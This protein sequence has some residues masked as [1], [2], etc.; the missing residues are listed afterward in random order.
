MSQWFANP[1]GLWLG[2]LVGPLLLLY[3]LRHK[4]VR[5]RVPSLLLWTGVAQAQIATS[6]FQRLKKSL[7][8]LLML[9]SLVALVLALSGL[10]IPGGEA[11]GVPVTIVIDTTASM[12]AFEPGGSRI[13]VARERA[14]EVI[15]AAGNSSITLLAWDGNLH[16]LVPADSEPAVA[17]AALD[18]LAPVQYGATDTALVR[19]L[20]HLERAGERRVVLISDHSPGELSRA[21]FVPCGVP[22]LNA[23]FVSAGLSEPRPGQTDLFFAVDLHGAEKPMRVPLTLERIGTASAE[24]VDARDIT[25]EPDARNPVTFANMRPGLYRATL[26]LDDGLMLDNTAFLRLSALPVQDVVITGE[27]PEPLARALAAIEETMGI[28][29]RVSH[30]NE[31]PLTTSYVFND[32]ASAG[33]EPRLPSAYLAPHAPPPGITFGSLEDVPDGATRPVPSFLWRGA[34]APDVRIPRL[35]RVEGARHLRP[36]LEAGPGAAIATAARDNGL[37]D[38][39]LSF[40]LDESATGFTERVAFLIFWANWFEH[41]RRQRDPLPRGSV[42]S[43]ETVSVRPI[44]GRT[45][46]NYTLTGQAAE[47]GTPGRALRLREAGVYEFDG[48]DDTDLPRLGVSL[49]DAGETNLSTAESTPMGEEELAEWMAGFSEGGER[50]DLDLR[51]WLALLAGGLLL[52]EWF[53][54]RRRFANITRGAPA[55]SKPTSVRP[56]TVPG[57]A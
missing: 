28:A 29:R 32:A 23:G 51:P 25:L 2:L 46:F 33:T 41:V 22:K 36:V 30:G 12:G 8:L 21:L 50:R 37:Q 24:L 6:P 52:F 27:T 9:L 54:F 17:E 55:G 56:R 26:K 42:T 45:D 31:A 15:N 19:A 5:K 20:E 44:T 7:S 3:M 43:R 47:A 49:L 48:L 16:T 10:R 40:P 14:R 35:H 53:W 57:R 34:G 18:Q 38:L 11:R 13:T 39:V 1:S 4:P